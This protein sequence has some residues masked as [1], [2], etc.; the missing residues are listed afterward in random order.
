MFSLCLR[1]YEQW[2]FHFES[3]ASVVNY[4]IDIKHVKT[5]ALCLF[6]SVLIRKFHWHFW[7]KS[8]VNFDRS[9]HCCKWVCHISGFL[10]GRLCVSHQLDSTPRAC[11]DA[12][13]KI[14]SQNLRGLLY[15]KY[16]MC[17]L[18]RSN[19]INHFVTKCVLLEISFSCKT[20]LAHSLHIFLMNLNTFQFW[21]YTVYLYH[22][23]LIKTL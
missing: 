11:P 5:S 19:T 12:H 15:S 2:T 6:Y 13:W 9:T 1:Q 20:T 8:V 7:W 22:K 18:I 16:M 21:Q 3:S 10:L 17:W 14:L 23:L 4:K